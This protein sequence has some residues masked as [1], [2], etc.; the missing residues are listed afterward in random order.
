MPIE[1]LDSSA[2]SDI[3]PFINRNRLSA[4]I[5]LSFSFSV[6]TEH[7]GHEMPDKHRVGLGYAFNA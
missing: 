4:F 7:L 5:R 1:S 3:F 2:R 6:G